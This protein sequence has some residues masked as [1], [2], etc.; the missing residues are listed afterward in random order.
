LLVEEKIPEDR[1][2]EVLHSCENVNEQFQLLSVLV[3]LNLKVGDVFL[4]RVVYSFILND[5]IINRN[6]K[7]GIDSFQDV[8][9]LISVVLIQL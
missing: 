2:M 8:E 6:S 1:D 3:A 9:L 4:Y 5:E 7:Q